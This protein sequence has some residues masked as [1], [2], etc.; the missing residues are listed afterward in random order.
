MGIILIG[1]L[2]QLLDELEDIEVYHHDPSEYDGWYCIQH[3]PIP[4]YSCG[5]PICYVEPPGL[6]LIVVWEEKDDE[7]M[8]RM[9]AKIGKIRHPT[10][11]PIIIKYAPIYG[12]CIPYTEVKRIHEGSD[13]EN[14]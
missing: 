5:N 4:C 11:D 7:D 1:D 6:H 9:A 8:L 13:D 12:P 14:D 10:F 2:S 3:L